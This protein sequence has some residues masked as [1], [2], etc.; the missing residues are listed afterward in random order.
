MHE[1]E[2]GQTL[3]ELADTFGTPEWRVIRDNFLWDEQLPAPGT[4]LEIHIEPPQPQFTEHTVRRGENLSI[5]ANR[6]GTSVRAIQE[7]NSMGT[8]TLI[9]IGQQILVPNTGR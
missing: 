7:A 6:Y 5:I 4:A 3:E 8:R 9:R 2:A 1:L